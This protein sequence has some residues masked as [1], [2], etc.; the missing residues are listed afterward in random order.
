[1]IT[2]DNKLVSAKLHGKEI[3]PKA[4]YRITTINY[5]LEGNDKMTAFRKG[6]NKVAPQ[7]PSNNTRFLIMNFF[8]DKQAKGEIVDAKVEGRIVV[9]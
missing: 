2:K 8:R 9:K 6:S 1:V 4:E 3:D 5:L 7:D